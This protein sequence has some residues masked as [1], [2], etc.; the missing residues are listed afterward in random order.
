MKIAKRISILLL[1]HLRNKTLY[2]FDLEGFRVRIRTWWVDIESVSQPSNFHLRLLAGTHPYFS[3]FSYAKVG[4][5]ENIHNYCIL[6]YRLANEVTQEQRFANDIIRAI[7]RHDER[8]MNM[9][10]TRENDDLALRE[11]RENIERGKMTRQQR[12][13]AERDTRKKMRDALNDMRN[14]EQEKKVAEKE[15]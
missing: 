3:L 10:A 15:G 1:F 6:V 14:E 13:K 7:G 9:P 2:K 12:R 11:V 8:I 5:K 4:D